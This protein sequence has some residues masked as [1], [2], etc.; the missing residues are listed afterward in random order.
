[1]SASDSRHTG[2][3][4]R[5]ATGDEL[6]AGATEVDALVAAREAVAAVALRTGKSR[7]RRRSA[8]ER[9]ADARRRRGALEFLSTSSNATC[10]RLRNSAI[11]VITN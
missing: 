2:H 8:W 11:L 3:R 7:R 5:S 10:N 4:A 9:S 6:D 1:V